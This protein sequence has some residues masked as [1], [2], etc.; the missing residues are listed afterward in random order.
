MGAQNNLDQIVLEIF[1]KDKIFVEAGGSDPI[2]QN[3]TILLEQNGWNGLVVEPKTNFNYVYKK[4][5]P[6]TILENYVLVNKN[7]PDIKISGDFNDYMMGGL[8]NIFNKPNWSPQD[9][10]CTTLQK[11]LE[12]HNLHE[13]H[14]LSLDT[15]G[16]E[17][18]IL[19]GIDFEKT[20]IHLIIVE[21][22]IVNGE[23]TNFDFLSDY[24]FSKVNVINQH[25]FFMNNKSS[26]KL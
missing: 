9:Y 16:S 21:T 4:L 20:F 17:K 23:L 11:L 7:Y 6:N 1:G 2:D 18:D 5:R 26:Y 19:Y 15:E 8:I 24:G 14:F 13:I 22:H 12:K 25:T 10:P 3:N